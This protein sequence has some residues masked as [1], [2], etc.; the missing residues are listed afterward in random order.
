[1]KNKILLENNIKFILTS[2][3][4]KK[5]F[6]TVRVIYDYN[7]AKLQKQYELLFKILPKHELFIYKNEEQ[8][9]DIETTYNIYLDTINEF[10]YNNLKTRYT[11]LFVNEE[12]V[13]YKYTQY[14]RREQ[15]KDEPL[16]KMDTIV[17]FYFCVTKYSINVLLKKWKIPLH[18]IIFLRN[19]FNINKKLLL[20]KTL[21]IQSNDTKYILF[22]L[23]MYETTNNIAI[24]DVWLTH[25]IN[26]KT[27]LVIHLV[28]AKRNDKLVDKLKLLFGRIVFSFPFVKY[29]ENIIITNDLPSL[30]FNYY[31]IILN[32]S[33][34]NLYYKVYEY[35]LQNKIII[36][37]DNKITR[38]IFNNSK[39]LY[40]DINKI[41]KNI[42]FLLESYIDNMSDI[43][44]YLRFKKSNMKLIFK[45]FKY[46]TGKQYVESYTSIPIKQINTEEEY[47][48]VH[49][50]IIPYISKIEKKFNTYNPD[51]DKYFR[52]IK[53]PTNK[54]NF[55]YASIIFINNTYL[56]TVLVTGYK[57]KQLTNLNIVCFVQDKPYYENGKK[58]FPG[59]N[60]NDI[61]QIRKIYDCVIGIDIVNKYFKTKLT[62]AKQFKEDE[63]YHIQNKY[64]IYYMTKILILSFV[65]YEKIFFFD[66][67]VLIN[68]NMDTMFESDIN[69]LP[70]DD[71]KLVNT[72]NGGY[73]LII[74]KKYYILKF[75]YLID[76]F[77]EI[78]NKNN[79]KCSI[80]MYMCITFYTI[81]PNFKT[82][83]HITTISGI[84]VDRYN[85]TNH[86]NV[87]AQINSYPYRKP[88]RYSIILNE[89]ERDLF[90][91]NYIHYGPWDETVQQLLL[92]YPK[93]KK[94]F[95]YIKT[96]RYT[97]FNI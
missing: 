51:I 57:L 61:E 15:Y 80:N 62:I 26:I 44:N 14:V 59:L 16:I 90:L 27:T 76:N 45:Y 67:S 82:I 10:C 12:Y 60:Y 2:K 38:E 48:K 28:R 58:I 73:F 40:S 53:K 55:C 47:I 52:F 31:A 5:K 9:S 34:Y 43:E 30:D 3:E 78:F 29:Y 87:I 84:D 46:D 21:T 86:K 32:M 6:N 33:R 85:D 42:D 93:F 56:P 7:A 11:I 54:T 66:A 68:V 79:F 65:Y 19:I 8:V 91:L 94:Y 81:Y 92:K 75:L 36:V 50:N 35:I 88:F 70:M 17:D 83:T 71:E 89:K 20:K 95:K 4:Q 96:F 74:P 97:K 37:N 13:S 22:D 63:E 24:L 18:K 23:D 69:L 64:K 49:E 77:D 25:Y 1:M 72:F 39:F 41:N